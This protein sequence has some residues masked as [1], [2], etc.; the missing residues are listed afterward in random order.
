MLPLYVRVRP[1]PTHTYNWYQYWHVGK[2]ILAQNKKKN[3]YQ[4][5]FEIKIKNSIGMFISAKPYSGCHKLAMV[6]LT[7]AFRPS[8]CKHYFLGLQR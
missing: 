7:F 3:K 4:Y 2:Y 5:L 1:I 6:Q 8:S